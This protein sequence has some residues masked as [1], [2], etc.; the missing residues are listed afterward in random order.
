VPGRVPL[1]ATAIPYGE[2]ALLKVVVAGKDALGTT[3]PT[4]ATFK[5]E[6]VT[7][8]SMANEG[9]GLVDELRVEVA[10]SSGLR[11]MTSPVHPDDKAV[12]H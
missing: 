4:A 2:I 11:S 1:R 6:F 5:A 8:P 10:R 7:P 9:L 3:P 12:F